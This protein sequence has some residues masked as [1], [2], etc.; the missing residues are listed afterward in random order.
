MP[1]HTNTCVRLLTYIHTK[2]VQHNLDYENSSKWSILWRSRGPSPPRWKCPPPAMRAGGGAM[3]TYGALAFCLL[4]NWE[5]KYKSKPSIQTWRQMGV[6]KGGCG[7]NPQAT[8]WSHVTQF[9]INFCSI[10]D[11]LVMLMSSVATLYPSSRKR[12]YNFL[13]G[14][15]FANL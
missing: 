6:R 7:I 3:G 12:Y 13:W 1:N 14:V 5:H 4:G 2:G 11:C 9:E 10:R 8:A 15:N